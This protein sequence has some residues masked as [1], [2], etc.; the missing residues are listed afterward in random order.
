MSW[1]AGSVVYQ[2]FVSPWRA[3]LL[4]ETWCANTRA[5]H[6]A[7]RLGSERAPRRAGLIYIPTPCIKTTLISKLITQLEGTLCCEE[8]L[9]AKPLTSWSSWSLN[10]SGTKW[11]LNDHTLGEIQNIRTTEVAPHHLWGFWP[12]EAD[13]R[14]IQVQ[15][16]QKKLIQ[17]HQPNPTA[18]VPRGYLKRKYSHF[19]KIAVQYEKGLSTHECCAYKN[20]HHQV[21]LFVSK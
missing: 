10:T 17:Q 1:E 2:Q 13:Q 18:E 16:Y 4:N 21:W 20:N 19:C 9:E 6:K 7:A 11:F 12:E 8:H 14:S 15:Q 5:R 3:K